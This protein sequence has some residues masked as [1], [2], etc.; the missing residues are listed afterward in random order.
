MDNFNVFSGLGDFKNQAG[1]GPGRCLCSVGVKLKPLHS[2]GKNQLMLL[3][4]F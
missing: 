2:R 4:I 3:L 1:G